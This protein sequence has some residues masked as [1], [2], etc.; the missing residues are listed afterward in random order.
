M[1][2]KG[3]GLRSRQPPPPPMGR[4]YQ[5]CVEGTGDCLP[6]P[7]ALVG[8]SPSGLFSGQQVQQVQLGEQGGGWHSASGSP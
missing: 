1:W 5:L 2:L 6:L 3:T 7:L 4:W 8:A